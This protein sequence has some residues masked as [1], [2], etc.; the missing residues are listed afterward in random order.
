MLLYRKRCLHERGRLSFVNPKKGRS[1]RLKVFFKIGA[2]KNL[3]NF[4]G[5]HLCWS[6]F[7]IKLFFTKQEVNGKK[8]LRMSDFKNCEKDHVLCTKVGV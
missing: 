4:T 6:L 8:G 5:K 2:F 1:S 3:Q 7:L